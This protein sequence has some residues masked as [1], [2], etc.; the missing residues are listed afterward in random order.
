MTI[1]NGTERERKRKKNEEFANTTEHLHFFIMKGVNI[2]KILCL[3]NGCPD[4]DF[5]LSAWESTL[6]NQS[7][8]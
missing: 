1:Q 3:I 7:L 8:K 2:S 5:M 4:M 6:I